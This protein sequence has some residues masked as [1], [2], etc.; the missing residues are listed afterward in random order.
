LHYF[1]HIVVSGPPAHRYVEALD[2]PDANVLDNL[3]QF[4]LAL[5]Y[6]RKLGV[7]DMLNFVQKPPSC[8][9]H[10]KQHADE[11]GIS[12][13]VEQAERWTREL[14]ASGRLDSLK[15]HGD[16]WHYQFSHG[17][18]E[19]S[20]W[21]V[22]ASE[23][24]GRP[25]MLSV[26]DSVC[27]RYMSSLVSDV[28]AARMLN[29]SLGTS[30][31]L[32]EDVLENSTHAEGVADIA[33]D[34]RLPV[35]NGV[36]IRD[37]VKIRQDE[38]EC[39][40]KFQH[41]LTTAIKARIADGDSSEAAAERISNDIIEPALIDIA[42]RLRSARK[43]LRKKIGVGVGIG[44]LVT[45]A[46]CLAGVPLVVGTGVVAA[47]TSVPSLQKFFDSKGS[48]ELSDMYFLWRVAGKAGHLPRLK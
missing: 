9:T 43:T 21:G 38:Q 3:R 16:H 32:H 22:V 26:A 25:S 18:L 27:A 23:D 7:E 5:L 37:I 47:G 28:Q 13:L 15:E 41:A 40:L 1:D 34:L 46:G 45:T 36:P 42:A 48:V 24:G 6:L 39:F 19:H 8:E 44:A 11:A 31:Q 29:L 4:V 35:L 14:A 12:E 2:D 20:V 30:V 33:F 10:W 17:Q